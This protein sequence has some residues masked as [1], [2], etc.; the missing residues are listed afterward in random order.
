MDMRHL[1]Q[2]Q[3]VKRVFSAFDC[4]IMLLTVIKPCMQIVPP[5]SRFPF[6]FFFFNSIALLCFSLQAGLIK[7]SGVSAA[8]SE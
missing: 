3:S 1:K 5:C 2:R 7:K 4:R 6:L 8:L